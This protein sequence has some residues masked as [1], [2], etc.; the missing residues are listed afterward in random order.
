MKVLILVILSFIAAT[1]AGCSCFS[2]SSENVSDN[3]SLMENKLSDASEFLGVDIPIPEYIPE[4]CHFKDVYYG[5]STI[6]LAYTTGTENGTYSDELNLQVSWKREITPELRLDFQQ[7]EINTGTGFLQ[8]RADGNL[9]LWWNLKTDN[10][11]RGKFE[12]VL[13]VSQNYS[14][15]ELVKIAESVRYPE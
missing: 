6:M 10:P 11:E 1:V 4:D 5:D 15:E 14:L 7:V 3:R 13:I 8:K 12:L 2:E 9:A